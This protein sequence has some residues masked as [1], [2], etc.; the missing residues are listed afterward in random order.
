MYATPS[1]ITGVSGVIKYANTVTDGWF[2]NLFLLVIA[3]VVLITMLIRGYE[4]SKTFLV[5][6]FMAFFFSVPFWIVEI[7]DSNKV[8]LCLAFVVGS[9]IWTMLDS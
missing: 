5:A 6:S 1:N 2:A 4:T 9:F 3:V 7:I 8:L